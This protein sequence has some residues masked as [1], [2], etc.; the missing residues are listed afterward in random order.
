MSGD[1]RKGWCPGVL[2]PMAAA[3]GLIVRVRPTGGIL[4]AATARAIADLAARYGNG[5]LDL[6]ARANLQMRGVRDASLPALVD[7]LRSLGLVD[8]EAA[9]EAVRNVVASPLAGLHDGPDIRPLV[10]A[11]E[12]RLVEVTAL[13]ALP[14]K[15][16]FLIDDGSA[17]SLADVAADVRF[18]W[19]G[20]AF[21]IGLGGTR[22][23]ALPAGVCGAGELV[24]CAEDIARRALALFARM[25]EATRMR[26]LIER[27][28]LT[29]EGADLL[30]PLAGEGGLAKRGRM[31]GGAAS[32]PTPAEADTSLFPS[33]GRER[34]DAALTLA[35]P[36]GRLEAAM[37]HV[38]AALAARA[39]GE[40]RLTPWRS[41]L[42]PGLPPDDAAA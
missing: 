5:K 31:R 13:H 35:A 34:R 23:A 21:A 11:L 8:C 19:R 32:L 29:G 9:A 38:A 42:L 15:F 10:A 28:D 33:P 3:D 7:A 22:D 41:L 30:L 26:A 12:A 1:L 40:L 20:D 36:Y 16:G 17:P 27:L 37:L 24:A 25:P 14:T 4:P 6:T 39:G 18:D 2:Q